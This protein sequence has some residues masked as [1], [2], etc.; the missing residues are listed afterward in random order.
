MAN[1]LVVNT[2]SLTRRMSGVERYTR[3]V[4]KRLGARVRCESPG[5]VLPAGTGHFWEQVILPRKIRDRELLW[6]PANS[7]PLAISS[8]VLTLHDISVLEHP[9]WFHPAFAAWY[10]WALP[11]LVQRVRRVLTVSE[12]S[13]MCILERFSLP[14]D[15]VVVIPGGVDLD[16][17]QP[18]AEASITEVRRRYGLSSEY[19]LY[20]G[21]IEPRKN[22]AQLLKDWKWIKHSFPWLEL[23]IAGSPAANFAPIQP[24]FE[25]AG[26]RLLGYVPDADLSALYSGA[27]VFILPSLTE[28][29]GLTVLEA[30]ACGTPVIAS[31]AGALPE[32]V[33]SAG[34]LVDPTDPGC[35]FEAL[36]ELLVNQDLWREF[37]RR[38][39]ERA[40]QF[41]WERTAE[42]VWG[43]LDIASQGG[44]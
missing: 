4:V 30:M 8:Q 27:R 3:E 23:V 13:R 6:S 39:L 25:Q 41:S 26:L 9:E 44:I 36:K 28:G 16:R 40:Q 2:R 15:R 11:R 34:W 12:H 29:F 5:G 7:G 1:G 18:A 43:E 33:G 17:F 42:E 37:R 24:L 38:G 32:T 22:L 19:L 14:A 31:K 20:I 35:L 21:T 10:R